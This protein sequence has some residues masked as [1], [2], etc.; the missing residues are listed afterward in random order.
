MT[1]Q[2]AP[3][4]PKT[5]KAPTAQKA[6]AAPAVNKEAPGLAE[7]PQVA[8][9]NENAKTIEK[10]G[11]YEPHAGYQD[12]P[13]ASL[14]DFDTSKKRA[15]TLADGTTQDDHVTRPVANKADGSPQ[16]AG[17]KVNE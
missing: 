5:N 10:D 17:V 4:A 9:E 14:A 16:A 7:P 3:A 13:A 12:D 2:K 8:L 11:V 6:P 15:S 1:A